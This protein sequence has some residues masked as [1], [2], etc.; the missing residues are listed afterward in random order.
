M[1]QSEAAIERIELLVTRLGERLEVIASMQADLL[2][3]LK[4]REARGISFDEITKKPWKCAW[5]GTFGEARHSAQQA[6]EQPWFGRICRECADHEAG[7]D[8]KT[9]FDLASGG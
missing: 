5:E 3:S 1:T 6:K 8:H 2:R 7:V 9:G 4:P